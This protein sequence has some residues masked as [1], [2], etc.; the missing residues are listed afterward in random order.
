[1]SWISVVPMSC[2]KGRL[3]RHG[4]SWQAGKT[5][6]AK[7]AE[8]KGTAFLYDY[9]VINSQLLSDVAVPRRKVVRRLSGVKSAVKISNWLGGLNQAS[10]FRRNLL[11]L[12]TR[13]VEQKENIG[14]SVFIFSIEVPC[15]INT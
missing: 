2:S 13:V 5:R 6:V 1:M 10:G 3:I 14:R 9:L 4:G 15:C 12:V 11:S 7:Q 8:P